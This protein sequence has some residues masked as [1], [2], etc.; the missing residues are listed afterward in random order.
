[1]DSVKLTSQHK[2][3]LV[4]ATL[5]YR[6]NRIE[7]PDVLVD[8]GATHTIINADVAAEVGIYA[9]TGGD[10]RTVRGV[11]G[12]EHVFRRHVRWTTA[13]SSAAFWEWTF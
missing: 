11:G 9:H 5:T 10:L 3:V 6:Q 8:T 1:V 12:T 2:C 13:S 4:T 7:I